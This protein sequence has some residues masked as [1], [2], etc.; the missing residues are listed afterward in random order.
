MDTIHELTDYLRRLADKGLITIPEIIQDDWDTALN[1][2]DIQANTATLTDA[3]IE[4]MATD[5][6]PNAH[7]SSKYNF[8]PMER[9]AYKEGIHDILKI[10]NNKNK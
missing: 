4:S 5:K 2:I 10:L 3:E 9:V 6:F 8:A 7:P 1:Q